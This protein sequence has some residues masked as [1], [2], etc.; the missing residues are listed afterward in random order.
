MIWLLPPPPSHVRKLDRRH[1]GR[2]RKRDNLLT[3]EGVGWWWARSWIIRP[4][5]N[6]W[7]S[8]NHSLLSDLT[9]QFYRTLMP[10]W[11]AFRIWVIH[12]NKG[13]L[14]FNVEKSTGHIVPFPEFHQFFGFC[15]CLFLPRII[16]CIYCTV[17]RAANFPAGERKQA[18]T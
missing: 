8:I 5:R 4:P 18:C 9:L 6:T 16:F 3:G 17:A 7:F 10:H 1:K 13:N 11:S 12:L 2:L 15:G 14:N